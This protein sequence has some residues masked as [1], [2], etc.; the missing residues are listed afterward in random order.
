M[1]GE[2]VLYCTVL[3]CTVLYC[4]VLYYAA[5]GGAQQVRLPGG[6]GGW[7]PRGGDQHQGSAHQRRVQCSGERHCQHTWNIVILCTVQVGDDRRARLKYLGTRL[8]SAQLRAGG[9]VPC[10]LAQ[11]EANCFLGAGVY[12][13]GGY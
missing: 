12:S 7:V 1:E 13:D 9:G 4:T 5:L 10:S 2:A 8:S 6:G 11:G 3:Y